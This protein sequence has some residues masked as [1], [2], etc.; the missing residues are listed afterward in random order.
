MR[1]LRARCVLIVAV[2]A[3][4]PL[5]LLGTGASAAIVEAD[6][7]EGQAVAAHGAYRFTSDLAPEPL[8]EVTMRIT[9]PGQ[10]PL[11]VAG[12]RDA[13]GRPTV[14][15]KT[16][17]PSDPGDACAAGGLAPNGPYTVV[18]E[19]SGLRGRTSQ[20]SFFLRIGGD[21][22]PDLRATLAER[23]ATVTWRPGP[24]PDVTSYAVA[25][26]RGARQ[27]VARSACSAEGVC[28]A[29]FAYA[30]AD[31]GS[32]VFSVRAARPCGVE[33][34]PD[35]LGPEATSEPVQL[36]PPPPGSG[37][38]PTAS[39][40]SGGSAG[41]P[42]ASTAGRGQ[43]TA[44]ADLGGF[45][46]TFNSFGP[47]LGLPKLPPLPDS[48]APAVAAP[49]V[50]DTFDETL[51]YE[52]RTE[53]DPV[54]PGPQAGRDDTRLTSTG[55]GLLGDEQVVRGLAGALV[56]ALSGAHLRTWLAHARRDLEL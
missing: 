55:A 11:V 3:A 36:P 7:A 35:A 52:D 39:A 26:D 24:E 13:Q 9:G 29:T 22:V 41:G 43:G 23:T 34:C 21:P 47:K 33:G 51:G 32:R 15:L 37:P 49:E 4:A 30:A 38:S 18:E 8:R 2:L 42:G 27:T 46:S 20:R 56:L 53:L 12:G 5:A 50:P 14:L 28:S 31:T 6:P 40:G 10:P 1:S 45:A 19:E 44:R 17:C 25:D 48:T 16:R 54:L